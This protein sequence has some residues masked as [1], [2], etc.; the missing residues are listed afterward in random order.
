MIVLT[1]AQKRALWVLYTRVKNGDSKPDIT[2]RQFRR[3][4]Q[5]GYD[6]LMVPV[7]NMWIGIE[8]DGY[9]HS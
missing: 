5:Y 4:V 2:Y 3:T 7:W 8:K 9:T 1:R 6:C